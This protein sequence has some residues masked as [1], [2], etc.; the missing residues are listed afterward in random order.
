MF[1]FL[2]SHLVE[3]SRDRIQRAQVFPELFEERKRQPTRDQRFNGSKS[4]ENPPA[5][6]QH[7]REANQTRPTARRKCPELGLEAPVQCVPNKGRFR[8]APGADLCV[9]QL[10]EP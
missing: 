2:G 10:P 6:G 7:L 1:F 5:N 3:A 8:V 9:Q 4:S